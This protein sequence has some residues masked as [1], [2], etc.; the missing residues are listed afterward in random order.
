VSEGVVLKDVHKYVVRG[1][2]LEIEGR[3]A[4]VL[5]GPNGSGK[6]TILRLAAGILKPEKGKVLV[7]G[8]DPYK[9][10]EIRGR[11]TYAA[12]MPLADVFET[13]WSYL[14]FYLQTTPKS[15]RGGLQEAVSYFRLER[16]LKEPVFKLSAGQRK[17][18]ELSK[19]LLRKAPYILVD[20]PT[21]NLDSDGRRKTADLLRKLS[22]NALVLL[23]TH[24]LDLLD[25]L[26]ADVVILRNGT[27]EGVYSYEQF[28]KISDKLQGGYLVTAKLSWKPQAGDPQKLLRRYGSKVEI[29]KVEIGY[30]ALLRGLGVDVSSLEGVSSVSVVWVDADASKLPPGAVF[31][32][33]AD[34]VIPVSIEL[35]ASDRATV[36]KLVEDLMDKG[37]VED[38]RISRVVR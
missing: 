9:D 14:S 18:L 13:C 24:E 23:A 26:E 3:D 20:E 8:K 17:R 28:A 5:L 30:A 37:E 22:G 35:V 2:T 34:L 27:I 36:F 16:V 32:A 10:H 7:G 6:T 4:Y 21:A 29:R 33:P 1:A 11:I 38:L 15:L 12:N 19:L 25:E 31:R